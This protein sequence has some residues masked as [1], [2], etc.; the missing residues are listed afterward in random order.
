[1]LGYYGYLGYASAGFPTIDT[2]PCPTLISVA[3]AGN[4]CQYQTFSGD[5]ALFLYSSLLPGG[6]HATVHLR[7][8]RRALEQSWWSLDDGPR[9]ARSVANRQPVQVFG[10]HAGL[11]SGN[12]D[13][14]NGGPYTGIFGVRPPIYQIYAANGQK[15]I[16]GIS[17]QR[18][19]SPAEWNAAAGFRTRRHF[20]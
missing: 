14:L 8:V 12:I 6:S 2:T 20:V 18:G 5:Y 15:R 17:R 19:D 11:R 10:C 3:A 7:P 16:N 1:M 13:N 4:P 9:N